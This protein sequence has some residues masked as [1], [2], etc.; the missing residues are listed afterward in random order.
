MATNRF[1]GK[2]S[3]S[4][5]GAG[6]HTTRGTSG[7]VYRPRGIIKGVLDARRKGRLKH[8]SRENTETIA[9]D[10][11]DTLKSTSKYAK[12]ISRSAVRKAAMKAYKRYK[13]DPNFSRQDYET[14]KKMLNALSLKT[15]LEK[16]AARAN[17]PSEPTKRATTFATGDTKQGPDLNTSTRASLKSDEKM[18]MAR[19]AANKRMLS[20]RVRF[21]AMKDSA[22][23]VAKKP[24]DIIAKRENLDG[25]DHDKVVE[26]DIG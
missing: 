7:G 3:I 1:Q 25:Q 16:K 9:D 26:L 13:T 22:E 23:I 21:E 20:R 10:M 6:S 2:I 18:S 11:A 12:G 4:S 17:V 19:V 5:T 14:E 24:K 8:L 15:Y